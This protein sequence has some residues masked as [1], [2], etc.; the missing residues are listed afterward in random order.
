MPVAIRWELQN[1]DIL[2]LLFRFIIRIALEDTVP[3]FTIWIPSGTDIK[4]RVNA[5]FF[6]FISQFS[7]YELIYLL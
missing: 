1:A 4:I 2:S 5:Y 6:P 3:S 7:R